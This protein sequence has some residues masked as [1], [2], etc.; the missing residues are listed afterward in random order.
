[1]LLVAS[2]LWLFSSESVAEGYPDKTCDSISDSILNAIPTQ[3]STPMVAVEI[4]VTTDLA[5]IVGEIRTKSCVDILG[6][7]RGRLEEIG[8]DSSEKGFDGK[9][10][11]VFIS[12]GEQSSDIRDGMHTSLEAHSSD[13]EVEA[14][15]LKD[16]GDQGLT[17]GYATNETPEYMLLSIALAHRLACCLT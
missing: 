5:H 12:I 13:G 7:V 2:N 10:Y 16:T 6:I 17:F 14:E 3:G 9:T 4:V 1:M 11:G 8:F 15:D